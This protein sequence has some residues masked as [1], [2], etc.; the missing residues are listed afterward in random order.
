MSDMNYAIRTENLGKRYNLGATVSARRV[1]RK[2][3]RSFRRR[4][5]R[6][7]HEQASSESADKDVERLW[8]VHNASFELGQGEVLGLIGPNGAGKSTLLKL[9]CKITAPTEGRILIQGRVGALLEVGA[10]FKAMLSGL[11]NLYLQ[12]AWLGM[13]K[14]EIQS[15]VDQIVEFSGLQGFLDTPVKRYSSGMRLRLSFS[16]AAHL[17]PEIIIIDEALAVG[18]VGFRRKCVIKLSE[19]AQSG[20]TVIFVSH[21]PELIMSL[22]TR[23]L[24]LDSGRIVMDGNPAEVMRAYAESGYQVTASSSD[25]KRRHNRRGNGLLRVTRVECQDQQRCCITPAVLGQ[26]LWLVIQYE[27]HS[28]DIH[29]LTI[30]LTLRNSDGV[31]VLFLSNA[32]TGKQLVDFP[33]KGQVCCRIDRLSLAPG[34]YLLDIEAVLPSGRADFLRDA[35]RLE[36]ASGPFFDNTAPLESRGVFFI[37]QNWSLENV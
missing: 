19:I 2:L 9:L 1:F 3:R 21:N 15:K 28:S 6:P 11:E 13:S 36:V 17:N 33:E 5:G 34:S 27:T 22:C 20:R 32:Q 25:L 14:R 7:D 26:P 8:A 37:D 30:N 23:V 12:G 18:D 29:D 24:W 10:G 16:V 4:F 35:H 31:P